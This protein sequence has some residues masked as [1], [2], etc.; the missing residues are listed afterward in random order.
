MKGIELSLPLQNDYLTTV[1]LTVGG[2]SALA[3]FDIDKTEDIKV[4]VTESLLLFQRNGYENAKLCF[5]LQNGLKVEIIGLDLSETKEE[6]P[7]DEISYALLEALSET[8]NVEKDGE[9][10]IR[11]TL[12]NS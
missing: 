10:L 3:G 2:V 5:T 6:A 4:C 7:E 8:A 12:Q 11:I 1:R 9:K